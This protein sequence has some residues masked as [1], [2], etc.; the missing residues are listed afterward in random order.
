[1]SNQNGFQARFYVGPDEIEQ[2]KTGAR[3]YISESTHPIEGRITQVSLTMDS[4]RQA[5]PVTAFFDVES[6]RIFSGMGVDIAVEIYRNEKAIVLSR[7]EL[8]ETDMGHAAFLADGA[9]ARQVNVQTGQ[10]RGLRVEITGGL[11]S[12]DMLVSEGAQQLVAD[13]KL[14]IVPALITGEALAMLGRGAVGGAQ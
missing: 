10:E 2:I 8:V 1:V 14:N 7:K 5:F 13:G 3:V 11:H 4:Q 12:G 6:R 9:I